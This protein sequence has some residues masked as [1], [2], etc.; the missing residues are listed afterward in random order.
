MGGWLHGT[1]CPDAG[2]AALSS[3]RCFW[4]Q[5]EQVPI[6][7]SCKGLSIP[8]FKCQNGHEPSTAHRASS[9]QKLRQQRLERCSKHVTEE[10]KGY[11]MTGRL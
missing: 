8:L 4:K 11:Q 7:S 3:G 2:L 6:E 9:L 5:L 10:I 1:Q